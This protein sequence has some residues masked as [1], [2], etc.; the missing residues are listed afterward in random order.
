MATPGQVQ[1]Y[2][3]NAYTFKAS[4]LEVADVR[5][6]LVTSSYSPVATASGHDEWADVAAHE[7]GGGTGYSEGGYP[8]V[9]ETVGVDAANDG[10]KFSSGAAIWTASGAGISAWRYAVA[11]VNGSLWGKTNPLLFY[12]LGDATPADIPQTAPG[13][14]LQL[15]CPSDGWFKIYSEGPGSFDVIPLATS[16]TDGLMSAADKA[17]LDSLSVTPGTVD[18]RD[19]GITVRPSTTFLNFIG[20][21]VRAYA[22]GSVVV[23]GVVGPVGPMGPSGDVPLTIMSS[24]GTMSSPSIIVTGGTAFT[25]RPDYDI[26]SIENETPDE[27]TISAPSGFSLRFGSSGTVA[28]YGRAVFQQ[29]LS[30]SEFKRII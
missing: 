5:I 11:Y 4:D 9:A 13:N 28:A 23:S 20:D 15:T 29:V 8:I 3:A 27:L 2:P 22:D 6:A 1:V 16:T 12:F 26:Q 21:A 7:I 18:I 10:Y 24:D 30:L 19:E 14:T 17:K 25:L